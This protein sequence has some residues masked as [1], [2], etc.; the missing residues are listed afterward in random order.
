MTGKE[1]PPDS[2]RSRAPHPPA[3]TFS[4]FYGEKETCRTGD[5]STC[6]SRATSPL[7]ALRGEG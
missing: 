7:P 4:P 2:C 5:G 1:M 3:G 6:L